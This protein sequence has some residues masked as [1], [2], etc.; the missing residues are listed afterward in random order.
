MKK[1]TS[2]FLSDLLNTY[3]ESDEITYID[4]K[5]KE[6]YKSSYRWVAIRGKVSTEGIAAKTKGDAK[7][8]LEETE[9]F[10]RIANGG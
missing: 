6:D 1:S 9:M 7:R 5:G 2:N 4:N 3:R 8:Q 10:I